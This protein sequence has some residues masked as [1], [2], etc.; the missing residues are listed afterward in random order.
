MLDRPGTI[1]VCFSFRSQR[2]S[3]RDWSGAV[4]PCATG[5]LAAGKREDGKLV[6]MYVGTFF[7]WRT[8]ASLCGVGECTET[9]LAYRSS[10]G[11]GTDHISPTEYLALETGTSLRYLGCNDIDTPWCPCLLNQMDRSC[12]TRPD[13]PAKVT[14]AAAVGRLKRTGGQDPVQRRR[15]G[16][17]GTRHDEGR[18]MRW[19]Q[20]NYLTLG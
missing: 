1:I 17:G 13:R 6:L 4:L 3:P 10:G 20:Q 7:G 2:S 8:W 16:G 5:R 18:C 15:L 12:L 9:G 11:G 19:R 14:G